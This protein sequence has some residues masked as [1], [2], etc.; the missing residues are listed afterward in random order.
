MNTTTTT[1]NTPEAVKSLT[2]KINALCGGN[3]WRVRH[4]SVTGKYALQRHEYC[5]YDDGKHRWITYGQYPFLTELAARLREE[6][7]REGELAELAKAK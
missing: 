5:H 4:S 7:T 3:R 6:L 1:T 2:K